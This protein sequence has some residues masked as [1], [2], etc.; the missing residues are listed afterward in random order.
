MLR[1]R[2]KLG[3]RRNLC[4]L[5]IAGK[6]SRGSIV[7]ARKIVGPSIDKDCRPGA[8]LLGSGCPEFARRGYWR[9]SRI[10]A[11]SLRH[12]SETASSAS[13]ECAVER[14][15]AGAGKK[16]QDYVSP[17]ATRS[18]G[19]N[20]EHPVF[21][22]VIGDSLAILAAQG[23]TDAFAD[24]P[25]VS[26]ADLAR[27]LSGLTRNDYYDWSKAARD[28]VAGKQKIDV[29]VVMLG[30]NDVQPLKDGGVALDPLSDKWK[31]L[32]AQR[33]ED[34]ARRSG[35]RISPCSG[36]ACPRCPTNA[37]MPRPSR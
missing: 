22:A 17:S 27:D 6:E 23:L 19:A 35:T 3:R 37:S 2:C 33:V 13:L 1:L 4:A 9:L 12:R 32:Y 31:T 16:V 8:L 34:L 5:S 26:I 24:R 18:P 11:A 10:P 36:S 21:I 7:L 29:A 30:I 20:A 14:S 28:L 15:G 25:D